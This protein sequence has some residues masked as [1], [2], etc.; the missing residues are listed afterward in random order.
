MRDHSNYS[1]IQD[2]LGPGKSYAD[3]TGDEARHIEGIDMTVFDLK[4]KIETKARLYHAKTPGLRKLPFPSIAIIATVAL[5]NALVW[6]AVGVVIVRRL[7]STS[8]C[9]ASRILTK[10]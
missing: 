7:H 8:S 5:V 6:I 10:L 3:I 2:T 9:Y 1:V 4:N